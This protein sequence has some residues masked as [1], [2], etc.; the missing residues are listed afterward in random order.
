M[1]NYFPTKLATGLAFC[2]RLEELKR[3]KYNLET[4]SPTLI[5]SPRRYGKTS[6]S[7]KAFE[8]LGWPY[9]QIDLYKAFSEED[10][11]KF[12]LR[13]I[14]LLLG[15]LEKTPQKLVALAADFF[16][17]LNVSV[18]IEKEGLSL[19]FSKRKKSPT[20]VILNA[21][22]RLH[23]LAE[24]RQKKIIVYLDE[25]QVVGQVCS[26]YAIEA[27][28]REVAQK[29]QYIAF[30]FSGSD[31]HLIEQLFSDKKRPFYKLC[32]VISLD[33]IS[34]L[35]Y[36]KQL[37][38]ASVEKWGSELS[39]ETVAAILGYTERHT[40]YLNKLCSILWQDKH[41]TPGLVAKTWN[42]FVLENKSPVERELS[43]LT[44]N[45]RKI[46]TLI[47]EKNEVV[48]PFGKAF[49]SELNM[50]N[51][52]AARAMKLLVNKDYILVD[53]ANNHYK[54]LDPLIKSVLSKQSYE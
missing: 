5:L 42:N 10:I 23:G 39:K 29:S 27:V 34:E 26:N 33:R 6:L 53:S 50:S 3:L 38:K 17:N 48:E 24:K 30:V 47:A 18:S 22:E 41:P 21:L 11:E 7:L 37:Q 45:Q 15:K 12:I 16:S 44:T 54:V 19:D 8:Q 2:N 36:E 40:Y 35:S 1:T 14:G 28:I 43:L 49:L 25:F 20:E 13:G 9:I 4:V 31:R 46:L 52:S 51:S 32:D